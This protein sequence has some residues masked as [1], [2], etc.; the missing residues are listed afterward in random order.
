[1]AELVKR[2]PKRAESIDFFDRVFDDWTRLMPF[3]RPWLFGRELVG[4]DVIHVDEFR[5]G[6][7]LVIRAEL[8]GIDPERDVELTVAG[9]ALHI[10]AERREEE[11]TEEKGYR[12]R[13]MR[14]GSFSRSLPLPSGVKESDI[15]ASYKDGILEVRVPAPKE[16]AT[17]VPIEK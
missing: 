8:P 13:E 10:Q 14:Y 1:M 3:R 4:D 9:G 17:R 6:D 5:K 16:T 2:E 15:H 7:E 12:H 11:H